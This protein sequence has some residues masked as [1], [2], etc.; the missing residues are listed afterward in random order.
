[1]KSSRAS[2]TLEKQSSRTSKPKGMILNP[3]TLNVDLILLLFRM[4]QDANT[5]YS[6][7]YSCV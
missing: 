7:I 6:L 4:I 3:K 2:P 1:M 5:L